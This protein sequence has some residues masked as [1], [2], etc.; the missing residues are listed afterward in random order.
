MLCSSSA[1]SSASASPCTFPWQ[2]RW[3]RH[4]SRAVNPSVATNSLGLYINSNFDSGNI[5]VVSMSD[6]SNIQLSIH[7]DPHC[8]TDGRAHFQCVPALF[9]AAPRTDRGRNV[10]RL[11]DS[12]QPFVSSA[13]KLPSHACQSDGSKDG[14]IQWPS[15]VAKNADRTKPAGHACPIAVLMAKSA[16]ESMHAAQASAGVQSAPSSQHHCVTCLVCDRSRVALELRPS[17]HNDN[18]LSAPGQNPPTWRG[19]GATRRMHSR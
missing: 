1:C 3:A 2:C 4:K 19:Q 13:V 5:D 6:S 8:E 11:S 16:A 15:I 9:V 17:A 7:E 14:H 18:S 12:M 10:S